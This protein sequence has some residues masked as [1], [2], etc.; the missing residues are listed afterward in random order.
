L[1]QVLETHRAV[2]DEER[3]RSS[4]REAFAKVIDC[5]TGALGA[6]VFASE[7]DERIV[8]HTCKSRACP[9]C[10]YQATRAWQRDQ[11]RE[12]PDVPYAHV[13]LTMPDRL[14]PL[15][16]QNRHLLHD[17]PVLGAKVL[18]DWARQKYGIRLLIVVIPHTFG[19]HLNFNSHLHILVSDGGLRE[20]GP[21]WDA[22][23]RLDRNALMPMWRYAVI[24]LLREA[25]RAG[26]LQADLDRGALSRLLAA[27]Y[28]RWWNIDI[29]RFRSKNQFLGYAGRYARRP[30]LA[31]HRLRG[32]GRQE[33]RFVTKDTRTKRTVE[34]TYTPADFLAALADHIPDRYR[35][36]VRYFGLLAPRAKGQ[37]HDA[38]FAVLGQK[39]LGKP[40]RLRWATSLLKS[41]GVDPLVDSAGGRMRWVGRVPPR[42]ATTASPTTGP[43]VP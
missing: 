2:W 20:D 28:E 22:T 23:A 38:V 19:R 15:F 26:V 41:F 9:S 1:K 27:Q 5:G 8:Y 35:H 12:L 14:W 18:Q 33:I 31:Q 34:T 42:P 17:L 6:E 30:P 16:R 29:K 4:V 3:T 40:S 25:A 43:V 37:T 11:W 24:T 39:R 13:T 10:G 32:S 7:A 21:Q 36:N